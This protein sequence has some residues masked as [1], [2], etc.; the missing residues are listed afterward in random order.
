MGKETLLEAFKKSRK[1]L[2]KKSTNDKLHDSSDI[3]GV[4]RTLYPNIEVDNNTETF[5]LKKVK[6]E[7][8]EVHN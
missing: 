7:K 2:H 3:M 6:G 1:H 8:N 4:I 5:L